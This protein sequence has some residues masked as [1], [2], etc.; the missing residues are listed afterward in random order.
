MIRV[1][2]IGW[3]EKEEKTIIDNLEKFFPDIEIY[4]K[5]AIPLEEEIEGFAG[6]CILAVQLN[7]PK[8]LRDL[9]YLKNITDPV[10]PYSILLMPDNTAYQNRLDLLLKGVDLI[11][12]P[13]SCVFDILQFIS[14]LQKKKNL[15]D[16]PVQNSF[17]DLIIPNLTQLFPGIFFQLQM[18]S[19]GSFTFPFISD[20]VDKEYGLSSQMMMEDPDYFF[21][22]V[23]EDE[24]TE[25]IKSFDDAFKNNT[26]WK[27]RFR[28]DHPRL[29]ILWL[30][31]SAYPQKQ[32]DGSILWFGVMHD[33]TVVIEEEEKNRILSLIAENTDNVVIITDGNRKMEWVN[34]SFESLTE[35]TLEE[36]KGLSPGELLLGDDPPEEQVKEMKDLFDRGLP[37][38]GEI[39]NF[40]KSG[41]PY[42]IYMDIQPIKNSDGQVVR[43]IAIETDITEKKK[44]EQELIASEQ[45]FRMLAENTND[46]FVILDDQ[47]Y[48]EYVSPAHKKT[49]GYEDNEIIGAKGKDVEK[50]IHPDDR[51]HYSNQIKLAKKYKDDKI[52]IVFRIKTKGG[53][54]R[55]RE[56][57]IRFHYDAGGNLL[58]TYVI[59]RD[60][61]E[62]VLAQQNLEIEHNNLSAIMQSSPVGLLVIDENEEIVL[63]NKASERLFCRKMEEL[64]HNR[65]GDFIGCVHPDQ[66]SKTCGSTSFCNDC[67]L[68]RGLKYVLEG[69][70]N[71]YDQ[72]VETSLITPDGPKAYWLRFSIE[73]LLL[74]G[75]KHV[76]MALI[77]ITRRK[78]IERELFEEKQKLQMVFDTIPIRVYWKDKNLRYLGAN[79]AFLDDLSIEKPEQ[80][81]HKTAFDFFPDKQLAE[82]HHEQ[83][84]EIIRTG[85]PVFSLVEENQPHTDGSLTWVEVNKSPLRDHDGNVIGVLCTYMDITKQ[86]EAQNLENQLY[87]AQKT[88]NIKQTFLSNMSHEMRTPLNGIIGITEILKKTNLNEQQNHYL[89]IIE[90]SSDSLIT[91]IN[92]V[93]DLS[94]IEAGKIE[95]VNE[96]VQS[97]VFHKRINSLFYSIAQGKGIDFSFRLTDD[98]PSFFVSDENKITQIFNNI[99]GNAIKFTDKGSVKITGKVQEKTDD[100]MILQFEIEDTGPGI[101]QNKLQEIFEEFTQVDDTKT[102][103]KQGTG[104]GLAITQSLVK[105]LGGV[106]HAESEIGK[107]AKFTF[108]LKTHSPGNKSA[109][110][111]SAKEEENEDIAVLDLS[112]LVVEDKKV[113]RMVVELMLESMGCSVD[114]ASNGL[115]ALHKVTQNNYDVVLMDIQMPVMDG[116]T[117]VK[118]MRNLKIDLP[119]IIGLSAEAM[120]GDAEKYINMGMDDYL[121]KP[122]KS[123]VLASC[124]AKWRLRIPQ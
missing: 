32:E 76:I 105:L 68:Y 74:N 45:R 31:A 50:F 9:V 52:Q 93:L 54:Y 27:R 36:V 102:R 120:E 39:L 26:N 49:Y 44:R 98:F 13:S 40:T 85:I 11:V 53:Q 14:N 121:T 73:P 16:T 110:M 63:A 113:N 37:Y 119:V 80:I 22:F 42:W 123:K 6:E 97:S 77:D 20:K 95:I 5:E 91:L 92:S 89:N 107:G 122:I 86:R 84:M 2:I 38:K 29:G 28:F 79:R 48:I 83:E 66:E 99:V 117:A 25:L 56:D 41:R 8:M 33:A 34:K 72:E 109:G 70:K 60:I 46:G 115:E 104:L 96:V 116:A 7:D 106:I 82:K 3:G 59:L 103:I 4:V 23:L 94:K 101:P 111:F 69:S 12:T 118:E 87:I 18:F 17:S 57:T 112:I 81:I 124:L 114:N 43:F 100:D 78:K 88:A 108:T 62:S 61:H 30:D 51:Q 65:C 35:Y 55:W 75:D 47:G 58:K 67:A 10:C 15:V 19:D 1:F 90:E 24:S 21:R 71:L 64:E